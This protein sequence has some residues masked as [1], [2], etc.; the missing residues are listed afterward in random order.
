MLFPVVYNATNQNLA[1]IIGKF[2]GQ[3]GRL[4]ENDDGRPWSDQIVKLTPE[5]KPSSWALT[6][7]LMVALFCY[8]S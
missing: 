8:V 1:S 5:V 7:A 4:V 2:P 3:S 6:R